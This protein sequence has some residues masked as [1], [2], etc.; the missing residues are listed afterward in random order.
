MTA[1]ILRVSSIII[2]PILILIFFKFFRVFLLIKKDV[3]FILYC[4]VIF[5]FFLS[6]NL[7]ISGCLLY[8]IQQTCF[9]QKKIIW[10]IGKEIPKLN[11]EILH[12]FTRGWMF[13]AKE[14]SNTK[15]KFIFK[16][17]KEMMTNKEYLDSGVNFWVKYWVKDP[18]IIRILNL[19]IISLFIIF[20]FIFFNLKKLKLF[21]LNSESKDLIKLDIIFLLPIFVWFFISTPAMRY[22]GYSAFLPLFI[23]FILFILKTN[24]I[25]NFCIKNS[26]LIL[27]SISTLYFGYK[28]ISRVYKDFYFEKNEIIYPWPQHIKLIENI[29]FKKQKINGY[30]IN[31]R[32]PTNKLIMN[33]INN[34]NNY[35]LHCGNIKMP[36]VPEKKIRCINNIKKI[37]GYLIVTNNQQECKKLISEE[38]A[39]Y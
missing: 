17:S 35:I 1:M 31:L 28:N 15:D 13:Y 16:Y 19:I 6:K 11:K 24:L 32:L 23:L 14:I 34:K 20:I 36:C 25:I 29:D 3:K 2:L 4:L 8:P 10:S 12:S 37:N 39:L 30:E 27:I 7:V 5:F 22:G 21:E 33:N 26:L 38:H 18:D 9:E